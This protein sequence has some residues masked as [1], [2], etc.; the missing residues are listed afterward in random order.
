MKK[1]LFIIISILVVTIITIGQSFAVNINIPGTENITQVS[2]TTPVSSDI[3]GSIT[4]VGF[5]I[6]E[7]VKRILMGVI[8]IF[9]VYIG[10]QMIISMGSDEEKLSAAKRQLWYMIVAL[11]FINIPMVLFNA[12]FRG[13]NAGT[14]GGNITGGS[15]ESESTSSNIFFNYGV[16]E[17]VT[18]NVIFFMEIMI[19]AA[20]VFMITLTGIQLLVSRGR[21]ERVTEA[22]NKILYSILAL[23]FVGLIEAWKAIAF[24]GSL[25]DGRNLFES[26]ANLALFF[27]APVAI[28]F[29]TLAGYYYITS[30]GDEERAKKA[31]SIVI[32]T[33][34]ATLILLASYTFLLELSTFL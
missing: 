19:F 5:S 12:F 29:L 28:F 10:I 33:F 2:L 4:Y 9:I 26:L 21:E 1:I 30:N 18:T 11:V 8:V 32:N 27:A 7:T 20:A 16:F 34:I 22:K 13:G 17:S 3:S 14:V 23:I 25:S 15:F 31:K 6:L 24:G